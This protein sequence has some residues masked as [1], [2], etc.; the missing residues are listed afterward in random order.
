MGLFFLWKYHCSSKT[1]K[2]IEAGEQRIQT[3]LSCSKIYDDGRSEELQRLIGNK[4]VKLTCHKSCVSIYTDKNKVSKFEKRK[5]GSEEYS[6][7]QPVKLRRSSLPSFN[8][9]QHCIYCGTD[10][11]VV[12]DKKHPDRWR[13][14]Y[15]IREKQAE[16]GKS[17]KQLILDTC[18]KRNDK[19]SSHVRIRVEG[20]VSDL[21]AAEGRYHVDCRNRFMGVP[22]V[23]VAGQST[24]EPS[25]SMDNDDD[26][27]FRAVVDSL[28]SDERRIWN[29]IEIFKLYEGSGGTS[30][31]RRNLIKA[32]T[33]K[34]QSELIVLTAPG[35]ASIVIFR[36]KASDVLRLTPNEDLDDVSECVDVLS[37]R[38]KK[39]IKD[40][41]IAKD[42]Y[43]THLTTEDVCEETS[44][45]LMKLLTSLNPKLNN[46]PP[47]L[48]IGN[49]VT[50]ILLNTATN[51]QIALGVKVRFSKRLAQFLHTFQVVCS[52]DEIL[53]FKRSAAHAAAKDINTSGITTDGRKFTQIV[54]DNFD[55]DIAS[56]NGKLS[57]HSLAM[58]VA[59]TEKS[60]F[61]NDDLHLNSYIKI[62]RIKR[63]EIGSVVLVH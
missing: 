35:Y 18:N 44:Q 25:K 17:I 62:P 59:Q 55:A 39:E 10:C 6:E 12:K 38:I 27:P 60:D 24:G 43:N 11:V 13:P 51:L 9:R 49:M 16:E 57:T 52:Y 56:Q 61:Q 47:A 54:V 29:S 45:T 30:L 50:G 63:N 2:L 1:G 34:F 22:S 15:M 5:R 32:L 14:A 46:T 20:A 23:A 42:Y 41:G 21:N 31:S 58:L 3:I 28:K 37:K 53:R 36:Q 7:E 19:W 8:F 40:I 4:D 33:D 26:K 48:L